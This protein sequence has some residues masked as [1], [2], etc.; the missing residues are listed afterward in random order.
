MG[1]RKPSP[2]AITNPPSQAPSALPTLSEEW[3]IAA[4]SVSAWP[5]TSISRIIID[6]ASTEP[7]KV[8]A[9][10]AG[11]ATQPC[12]AT[13][14]KPRSTAPSPIDDPS[15]D[16]R[17]DRSTRRPAAQLPTTMPTP[18]V[19][20]KTGTADAGSPLTSVTAGAM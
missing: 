5:A 9:K 11:S 10:A 13:A 4:P 6:S 8:T 16:P 15:S 7:T 2:A 14:Q 19:S 12:G 18:R 3:L 1:A 17:T 20:R